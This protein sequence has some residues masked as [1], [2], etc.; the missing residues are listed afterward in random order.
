MAIPSDTCALCCTCPTATVEWDSFSLYAY[1]F[2]FLEFPGFVSTPPKHYTTV[3]V[4]EIPYQVIAYRPVPCDSNGS[5]T[6]FNGSTSGSVTISGLSIITG[7]DST[8]PTTVTYTPFL[9]PPINHTVN[10]QFSYLIDGD[11]R[12][13]MGSFPCVGADPANACGTGHY[14]EGPPNSRTGW[15]YP[16]PL[17]ATSATYTDG[18]TSGTAVLSVELTTAVFKAAA[19]A[20]TP[21]YPGTWNG[22]A[23]SFFNLT[24]SE[25][26]IYLR[27]SRYRLRF[28][29]PQVG[30]AKNY[31]ASWVERFIAEAGVSITSVEVYASGVYR[32]TVTLTAPPSGGVQAYATAVMSSTGTITSIAIL[33]PGS[34][35]ISAPSVTVQAAT[36]GGTSSTGWTAT[37]TAGQVTAISGGSAGNYRP[38]L[39]FTSGGGSGATA[40]CTLDSTGGIAAVTLTAGGSAYISEP[41]L[42]ITPKV[43]ASTPA[44]LLI[45][46]G[47]E[48]AMCTV[49]DGTTP[50]GYVAATS[51]T[52]P[53]LPSASPYY[54]ALSVPTSDGTTFV[55]NLRT[56]CDGSSCP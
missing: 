43:T 35:Y 47:T 36:G 31:R 41:T 51:S 22:T 11:S 7:C 8:I 52:W 1:K 54:F 21:T 20:V 28:K 9:A 6:S 10:R 32:P 55:A 33:H 40:T 17:S 50:S 44:D 49:W 48:T 3:T 38:T 19:L 24:P 37:L 23:G 39:A 15:L 27:A 26:Q 12:L 56:V 34:G 2:G 45:H 30:T 53:I 25:D 42:T 18:V 13:L 4:L 14:L 5:S 16:S 29:I 46:L